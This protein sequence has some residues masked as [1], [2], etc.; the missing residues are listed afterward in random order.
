M[1]AVDASGKVWQRKGMNATYPMGL[2][3]SQ[4]PGLVR[5]LSIG[6]RGEMWAVS[7]A[8]GGKGEV[9]FTG[10]RSSRQPLV[11]WRQVTNATSPIRSITTDG[12][13]RVYAVDATGDVS[14]RRGISSDPLWML[15]GKSWSRMKHQGNHST[16]INVVASRSGRLWAVDRHHQVWTKSRRRTAEFKRLKPLRTPSAKQPKGKEPEVF[17]ITSV[18]PIRGGAVLATT[19]S[20]HVLYRSSP[21][22]RKQWRILALTRKGGI[23]ALA[24]RHLRFRSRKHHRK[25]R[26]KGKGK[27]KKS[28]S[29]K[30]AAAKKPVYVG[31]QGPQYRKG[32]PVLWSVDK[33]GNLYSRINGVHSDA[34]WH[35]H[36][37][38]DYVSVVQSPSGEHVY[39]L[40]KSGEVLRRQHINLERNP[41]GAGWSKVV[42]E[43]SEISV[44]NSGSLWGLNAKGQ[45]FFREHADQ[46]TTT[47]TKVPTPALAKGSIESIEARGPVLAVLDEGGNI[48]AKENAR[49]IKGQT[50]ESK[51]V[52]VPEP[53]GVVVK[54]IALG[55]R[56]SMWLID[57]KHAIW[58]TDNMF[59][60]DPAWEKI[61]TPELVRSVGVAA[62]GSVLIVSKND[63]LYLRGPVNKPK[64][65][66]SDP[67]GVNRQWTLIPT[68]TNIYFHTVA[69]GSSY[70][71]LAGSKI[72]KRITQI[73]Q[74]RDARQAA[75]KAAKEQHIKDFK[76]DSMR[77]FS[78][79]FRQSKAQLSLP[80]R[81]VALLKSVSKLLG[82]SH[83]RVRIMSIRSVRGSDD[84]SAVV[85]FGVSKGR[86]AR[87][88]LTLAALDRLRHR[89]HRPAVLAKE[90]ELSMVDARSFGRL[91]SRPVRYALHQ[92]RANKAAARKEMRT[93]TKK[94]RQLK[95]DIAGKPTMPTK[96]KSKK[97]KGKGKGKK[98]GKKH[99]RRSYRFQPSHIR[100]VTKDKSELVMS[101][102]NSTS[103]AASNATKTAAPGASP[104]LVLTNPSWPYP[105]SSQLWTFNSAGQLYSLTSKGRRQCL[106]VTT[107]K[108]TQ[109]QLNKKGQVVKKGEKAKSTL[110][111]SRCATH[112]KDDGQLFRWSRSKKQLKHVATGQCLYAPE[113]KVNGTMSIGDCILAKGTKKT[114][115]VSVSKEQRRR[116]KSVLAQVGPWKMDRNVSLTL[117]FETDFANL[118][119]NF[120]SQV[121]M[122]L[123]RSL[124]V[125]SKRVEVEQTKAVTGK[126]SSFY[127]TQVEFRIL[128]ASSRSEES[129]RKIVKKLRSLLADAKSNLRSKSATFKSVRSESLIA[130]RKV[131][132]LAE[133]MANQNATISKSSHIEFSTIGGLVI[134]GAWGGLPGRPLVVSTSNSLSP[135]QRWQLSTNG[136]LYFNDDNHKRW[137]A[138]PQMKKVNL[139]ATNTTKEVMTGRIIT[140]PCANV[141]SQVWLYDLATQRLKHNDS[142]LCMEVGGASKIEAG[143]SV[144]LSRCDRSSSQQFDFPAQYP[145]ALQHQLVA[146]RASARR[147][148]RRTAKV[149]A[150]VRNEQVKAA[151]VAA[152]KEAALKKKEAEQKAAEQKAL[153]EEKR[154]KT[155]KDL[156]LAA[157]A[158]Q[159]T[160]KSP[161]SSATS[162][163][164]G[165]TKRFTC[166]DISTYF[167]ADVG[168]SIG[169]HTP[170]LYRSAWGNKRCKTKSLTCEEM[171][172]CYAGLSQSNVTFDASTTAP[173]Q[174][175]PFA[176]M[177]I[178]QRFIASCKNV[179]PASSCQQLS[180]RYG[181][182]RGFAG[183][184]P[185]CVQ[186][187]FKAYECA[188]KPTLTCR[189]LSDA[190]SLGAP[191]K[192]KAKAKATAETKKTATATPRKAKSARFL[193]MAS[194][195]VLAPTPAPTSTP[196]SNNVATGAVVDQGFIPSIAAQQA[197]AAGQCKTFPRS[198]QQLSDAFAMWPTHQGKAT[199]AVFDQFT[200][201]K[202]ETRPMLTCQ[203]LSDSFMFGDETRHPHPIVHGHTVES[204]GQHAYAQHVAAAT[205]ENTT[206]ADASASLMEVAA[207]VSYNATTLKRIRPRRISAAYFLQWSTQ[208]CHTRPHSCQELSN[209]YGLSPFSRGA[210]TFAIARTFH[211]VLK[212]AT[213]PTF[214]CDELSNIYGLTPA[215]ARLSAPYLHEQWLKQ[216]CTS[217]VSECQTLSDEYD[218]PDGEW[219]K[220]A[221]KGVRAQFHAYG[222]KTKPMPSCQSLMDYYLME[223]RLV[224][225]NGA[226]ELISNPGL[227]TLLIQSKF[228]R[229]QCSGQYR[230][231]QDLS[232]LFSMRR[233][234]TPGKDGRVR[235]KIEAAANTP[236]HQN[237]VFRWRECGTTP[238][239]GAATT[240]TATAQ[241]EQA[242][243]V[244]AAPT[245]TRTKV[246]VPV[247]AT[248]TTTKPA[249]VAPSSTPRSL[250]EQADDMELEMQ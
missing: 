237:V 60:T 127:A 72:D 134:E 217:F 240:T 188:T 14:R 107:T 183:H 165:R 131:P 211:D 209:Q 59:A 73:G 192:A 43:L 218:L 187:R 80:H 91:L 96:S 16:F 205:K 117:T 154:V 152:E 196:T 162:T 226:K 248:T 68:G 29:S 135:F 175:A 206:S 233:V 86:T 199:A 15:S 169:G 57:D 246:A 244:P 58:Y 195:P 197:F 5:Q 76:Q 111:I 20:G 250:I 25:S 106:Q 32:M 122:D 22:R 24:A 47:W 159:P 176:P 143:T 241:N 78:L 81:R 140:A 215:T 213:H 26:G 9:L 115:V 247:T 193:Q 34:K 1:W 62:D 7:M 93:I 92:H 99:G 13:G 216:N 118:P 11:S 212:C 204:L 200:R 108:A 132:T 101:L 38:K 65:T 55:P 151:A 202:C 4:V 87:Q 48:W 230:S 98:S 185:K 243:T 139:T 144:T 210:A 174:P 114:L 103:N 44:L 71:P 130:G 125:P 245:Q 21:S 172:D 50:K 147:V 179:A 242:K 42:G 249:A 166:R 52:D 123:A 146:A 18:T 184:A 30:P 27:G 120:K 224:E 39:A 221:P 102:G 53:R 33:E 110:G 75:K 189:R 83:Q 112:R 77:V 171:V 198:C 51:Y 23:R 231:C 79:L 141:T 74:L 88:R 236:H 161:A 170:A 113:A 148:E 203:Q 61:K 168:V 234:E 35:K 94:I 31:F 222:C 180:D 126:S 228:S 119:T 45:L 69:A 178:A 153:A 97:G 6:K 95:D 160:H 238:R 157:K 105:P 158:S 56:G 104:A 149:V 66:D 186:Q 182:S 84:R 229:W 214:T 173:I 128:G 37:G 2:T 12:H 136:T 177:L 156:K 121:C 49:T 82:V 109:D 100:L 17:K 219:S 10:P 3:W 133:Q 67:N 181:L 129:T 54:D 41:T 191:P 225:V 36:D 190:Y 207:S 19:S 167:A 235:V 85:L 201:R 150:T 28:A 194:Q 163:A 63:L 155:V 239:A 145:L 208:Q 40:K 227:A 89:L 164:F 142:R 137:C 116:E 46:S 124:G 223:H 138:Q 70:R 90:R 232:D 8:T 220:Y 64:K